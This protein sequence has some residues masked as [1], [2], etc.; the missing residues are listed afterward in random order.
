MTDA[1]YDES[2]VPQYGLPDPLLTDDGHVIDTVSEWESDQRPKLLHIFENE[3]Y[4]KAPPLPTTFEFTQPIVEETALDGLAI[5]RQLTVR[6]LGGEL[7]PSMTILLY[8]PAEPSQP[9]DIFLGLNFGGNHSLESD[10]DILISEGWAKHNNLT[11]LERGSK[12]NRWSVKQ[13]IARGYGLATVY[14]ADI[15]S[16][17]RNGYGDNNIYSYFYRDGQSEPD[18]DEWGAISAWAWGLRRAMDYLF[19]QTEWINRIMLMGHS[20]LGKA[21]LWAAAQ[22]DRCALVISNNSG[23]M[24]AA[25]SR[26]AFGETVALINTNW[27]RWL[28]KDFHQYSDREADLPIDQHTLISLIAPRPVYIA[29]AEEDLWADPLGEFLGGYH[30]NPVYM[31]YGKQGLPSEKQPALN[32]PVMGTIGYHKRS[33]GHDVT[34]YDWKQYLDFADLHLR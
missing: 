1:N 26:R 10:E 34:D 32:Q 30:A 13:I 11:D 8:L 29:S 7:S 4:G 17:L 24:G 5:R 16:D 12:V 15:S 2:K 6:L 14:H 18:P 19:Q 22:D 33:G 23:C 25:L 21:A 3:I 9:V 27:S 20:R 28:C 31:L